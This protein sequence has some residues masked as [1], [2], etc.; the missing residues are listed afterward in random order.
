M[1]ARYRALADAHMVFNSMHH[2]NIASWNAIIGAYFDH[3][4]SLEALQLYHDMQQRGFEP[5]RITFLCILGICASLSAY[6][7]GMLIHISIVVGGLDSDVVLGT[8]LI[9]M[10][11]KCGA[12]DSARFMFNEMHMHD[13]VS[14]NAMILAYAQ[15][16]NGKE[17]LHLFYEMQ[18]QGKQPNEIT[19]ISLLAAFTNPKDLAEGRLV[20]ARIVESGYESDTVVM[21]A[22]INMYGKCDALDLAHMAFEKLHRHDAVSWNAMIL[23]CS[24]HGQNKEAQQLFKT[25][26]SQGVEPNESTFIAILTACTSPAALMYGKVV[27]ASIVIHGVNS[28]MLETAIVQMYCSCDALEEAHCLFYRMQN[29]N[30]ITWTVM[31][32]AYAQRGHVMEALHL[33]KEMQQNSMEPD[34]VAFVSILSACACP[35]VLIEVKAIH[36]SIVAHGFEADRT[37]GNALVHVYGKCGALEDSWSLFNKMQQLDIFSCNAMMAVYSQHGHGGESLQVFEGMVQVGIEPDDV[38]FVNLLSACSHA[39]LVHEGLHF[40]VSMVDDYGIF[41]TLDHFSCLVDLL[42]RSGQLAETEFIVCK[43]PFQPD[44]VLWTAILGA[45]KTHQDAARATWAVE[46]ICELD[47]QDASAYVSLLSMLAGEKVG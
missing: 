42:G 41:P 11:S 40:F 33:F 19:Y 28:V 8:A 12:M 34:L 16:G 45:C 4:S 27:H 21:T 47:P 29:R 10:Y 43:M 5:D 39:G 6:I 30:V 26:Q 15:H 7:E 18:H 2:H 44:A 22:I 24:Q 20:H 14:C 23:V 36:S 31:I 1:A 35:T 46:S 9:N 37:V 38:T 17:A 32:G 3:G 25:M 13:L